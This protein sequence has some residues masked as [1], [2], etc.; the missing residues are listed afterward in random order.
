MQEQL[1]IKDQA[2]AS[3]QR[4]FEQIDSQITSVSA[5]AGRYEEAQR[6]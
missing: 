5:V 1:A 3:M 4:Q 2:L 6:T